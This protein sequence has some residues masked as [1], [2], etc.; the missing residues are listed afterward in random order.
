M[1]HLLFVSFLLFLSLPIECFEL[2][3]DIPGMDIFAEL[4]QLPPEN[5]HTDQT[6]FKFILTN[7]DKGNDSQ[8]IT[9]LKW[10]TPLDGIRAHMFNVVSED[11][12]QATYIGML[13][14]RAPPTNQ[15]FAT[16]VPGQSVSAIVD[17][18]K[19]YSLSKATTYTISLHS[20]LSYF[21]PARGDG[22]L[23]GGS[24]LGSATLISKPVQMKIRT[25]L[26]QPMRDTN[27]TRHLLGENYKCTITSRATIAKTAVQNAGTYIT[28]SLNYLNTA[29]CDAEYVKWFG[30]YAGTSNW[31]IIKMHFQKI[32]DLLA[33]KT[34][35]VD[36]D[37]SQCSS[38]V[39]AYVYPNDSQ[40]TVNL[41]SAFWSASSSMNYDCQPGVFIHEMSHFTVIAGTDDVTYGTNGAM[42]LAKKTPNKAILNADNHEYFFESQPHC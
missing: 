35:A 11:H 26:I 22:R 27:R 29:N 42:E 23:L 31:N 17:M 8:P 14:K 13:V 18:A 9:F 2:T 30:K 3:N 1:K 34:F 40:L 20:V 28:K 37:P 39:Y 16:L 5:E 10:N 19:A 7:P 24:P 38:G 15:D 12:E 25:P 36:C 6:L 41:C 33:K 4:E 21:H 32:S